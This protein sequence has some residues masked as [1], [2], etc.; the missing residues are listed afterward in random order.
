[1]KSKTIGAFQAKTHLSELLNDVAGGAVITITRRGKAV[2][3][4]IPFSEEQEKP[5]TAEILERFKEIRA[6]IKGTVKIKEFVK[7]GRKY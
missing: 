3:Q 5:G 1:M 2:A 4:I 6:A 7:Q